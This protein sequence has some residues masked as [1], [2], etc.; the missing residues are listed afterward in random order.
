MESP[1]SWSWKE[2]F[3]FALCWKL[4]AK[5]GFT[6]LNN[7]MEILGSWII[8]PFYKM[9]DCASR[10]LKKPLTIV[11]LTLFSSL[12][13][14]IAFY[15]IP[16]FK[17]LGKVVPVKVFRFLIFIYIECIF[18]GMGCRAFGRFQNRSLVELWKKEK[19]AAL[20]PGDWF[21]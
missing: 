5:E 12:I 2:G 8:E 9:L 19:L 17:F 14:G 18:F 15:N 21:Y 10:H 4:E 3:R 13:I 16:A 20:F 11:L 6:P 7:K 1:N